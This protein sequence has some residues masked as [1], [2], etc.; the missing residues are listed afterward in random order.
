MRNA[1]TLSKPTRPNS[2][3]LTRR[4]VLTRPDQ[5]RLTLIFI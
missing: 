1:L 5:T 2:S 3:R 4:S